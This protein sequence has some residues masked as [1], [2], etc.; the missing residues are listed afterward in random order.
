MR[1]DEIINTLRNGELRNIASVT[2][3]TPLLEHINMAL[4]ELYKRFPIYLG[5]HIV[6]LQARK[7]IYNMPSDFMSII[8]AYEEVDDDPNN[9]ALQEVPVNEDDNPLSI[10]TFSYN[11]IGIPTT[12]DWEYI[13]IIYKASPA[14]IYQNL[15]KQSAVKTIKYTLPQDPTA[16]SVSIPYKGYYIYVD[17]RRANSTLVYDDDGIIQKLTPKIITDITLPPQ[18]IEALLNYV[19]YRAVVALDTKDTSANT[20][21]AHFEESCLNIDKLGLFTSNYVGMKKRYEKGI[22]V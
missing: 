6:P 2:E 11:Q 14:Y 8:S 19:A 17:S 3:D 18:T 13:S 10:N 5:E 1:I 16:Y 15:D 9:H 12:K 7:T 22:W 4:L 20:Y 21:Y